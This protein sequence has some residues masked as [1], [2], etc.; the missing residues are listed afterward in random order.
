MT[1]VEY[2]R[3]GFISSCLDHSIDPSLYENNNIE[4]RIYDFIEEKPEIHE[5]L[6]LHP[7]KKKKLF[8]FLIIAS[9]EIK[10]SQLLVLFLESSE[11]GVKYCFINQCEEMTRRQISGYKRKIQKFT[12]NVFSNAIEEIKKMLIEGGNIEEML[13]LV[14]EDATHCK[15][16]LNFMRT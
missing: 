14:F 16:L 7:E 8:G 6:G 5:L 2:L 9:M 11:E 1:S 12:K 10:M 3:N 4:K 13:K 15:N